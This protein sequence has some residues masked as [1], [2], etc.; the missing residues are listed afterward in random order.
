MIL[1]S[2]TLANSLGDSSSAVQSTSMEDEN[3]EMFDTLTFVGIYWE[4]EKHKIYMWTSEVLMKLCTAEE[5]YKGWAW[6]KILTGDNLLAICAL[7]IIKSFTF[8]FI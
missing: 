5:H 1:K 2:Y 3:K 7:I 6:K 8:L 4:G